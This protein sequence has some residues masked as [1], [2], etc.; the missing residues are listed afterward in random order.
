M[1]KIMVLILV[2]IALFFI[3]SCAPQRTETIEQVEPSRVIP[4]QLDKDVQV[5][6]IEGNPE[7]SFLADIM[8]QMVTRLKASS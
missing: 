3:L 8:N 6:T 2:I 1:K 7:T 5:I 4:P